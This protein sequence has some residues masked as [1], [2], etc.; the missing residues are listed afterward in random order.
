MA[1]R[2]KASPEI[3][4][5]LTG[6]QEP[7]GRGQAPSPGFIHTPCNQPEGKAPKGTHDVSIMQRI[8]GAQRCP[9]GPQPL[10]A[11][12]TDVASLDVPSPKKPSALSPAAG[13]F[14]SEEELPRL[15]LSPERPSTPR[16]SPAHA[17]SYASLHTLRV[18][19]YGKMFARRTEH[20]LWDEWDH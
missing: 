4:P 12:S 20:P 6:N 7:G 5:A 2:L 10:G 14:Q 17:S 11:K 15:L 9:H 3:D 18:D 16:C 13:R 1:R 8:S 19:S